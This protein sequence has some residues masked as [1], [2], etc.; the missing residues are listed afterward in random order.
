[1]TQ[2]FRPGGHKGAAGPRRAGVAGGLVLALAAA[3]CS[4]SLDWRRMQP[5][6]WGLAVALPCRPS[7]HARQVVLADAPVQLQLM[8]CSAGEH[9]FAAASADVVDP[10]RVGPALQAL[11]AAARTN[12]QGEVESD[13]PAAVKGMTPHPLA[14]RWRLAGRL[15]DGKAVREQ[16][17]VFAHG[18]RVF[19]L[20]VLGPRSDDALARPLLDEAEVSR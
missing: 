12:V 4:P 18:T 7:T 14:R 6:G 2:A 10:A 20:T 19:Q 3:G 9:T 13:Q 5:E 11:G 17:L 16:V 8:A 15:P 1:M